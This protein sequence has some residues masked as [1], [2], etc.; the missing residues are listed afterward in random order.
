M[1]TCQINW[2]LELTTL[3]HWYTKWGCYNKLWL[4]FVLQVSVNTNITDM[5]EYLEHVIKQTNMKS[6]TPFSEEDQVK[7]SD[8]TYWNYNDNF[9]PKRYMCM[10]VA[11]Y[12]GTLSL[13]LSCSERYNCTHLAR[14]PSTLSLSWAVIRKAHRIVLKNLVRKVSTLYTKKW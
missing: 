7:Y 1:I 10:Y 2:F 8:Q 11:R 4:P 6:I 3:V 14:Y 5:Y 9:C 12:P 13:S